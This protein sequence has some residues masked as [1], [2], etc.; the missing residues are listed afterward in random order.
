[1][2]P[3]SS[4]RKTWWWEQRLPSL[5]GDWTHWWVEGDG[6]LIVVSDN[7]LQVLDSIESSSKTVDSIVAMRAKLDAGGE[8]VPERGYSFTISSKGDPDS[9]PLRA[10]G[11]KPQKEKKDRPLYCSFCGKSQHEIR[12]LI[13]GP[14]VVFICDEC[15]DL[16]ND[17]IREELE[18]ATRLGR[19]RKRVSAILAKIVSSR[20][21][22]R[23]ILSLALLL[24]AITIVLL[25]LK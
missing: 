25:A 16:C 24:Q 19:F 18:P 2:A 17:I 6:A 12:K 15:V 1:M 8:F 9:P 23:P 10:D 13:A 22:G 21:S 5:A 7:L 11:P 3:D 14:G 4:D 20:W